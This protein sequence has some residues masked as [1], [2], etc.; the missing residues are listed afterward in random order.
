ML[1]K[2]RKEQYCRTYRGVITKPNT[3]LVAATIVAGLAT[4]V[5]AQVEF[6]D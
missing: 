3:C 4:T 2:T 1:V 5:G 6:T